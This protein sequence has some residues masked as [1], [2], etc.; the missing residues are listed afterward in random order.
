MG[1]MSRDKGQRLER[2]IVH[3]LQEAGIPAERVPLSGAAGGSYTGDILVADTYTAEVKARASGEGFATIDRWL[4]TNDML[5]LRRDRQPPVVVLPWE[6]FVAL[7]RGQR[8]TTQE[9]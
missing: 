5:F 6:Q 7:M 1:K 8:A 3:R 9:K 4:G 2:E